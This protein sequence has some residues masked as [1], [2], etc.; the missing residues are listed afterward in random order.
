MVCDVQKTLCR[1]T[2]MSGSYFLSIRPDLTTHQTKASTRQTM[3]ANRQTVSQT[4]DNG[5]KQ[6]ERQAITCYFIFVG[7]GAHISS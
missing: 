7:S 3:T 4:T 2:E 5:R 1:H 6:T